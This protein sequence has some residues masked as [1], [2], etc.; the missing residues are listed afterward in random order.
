MGETKE[1]QHVLWRAG[2]GPTPTQ[3][4][5]SPRNSEKVYAQLQQASK[6]VVPLAVPLQSRQGKDGMGSQQETQDRKSLMQ[7]RRQELLHIN[8]AWCYKMATSPEQLRE[9]MTFF[10]HG[11]FACRT[12]RPDFAQN[13]INTLRTHALGKFGDLL[14]AVAQDPAMLQFLNNQQ[15]RKKQPN[16]NFAREVM[17]LFTLGR[18]QYTEQDIK[19]AARA[20]TGWG[21]N[22]AGNYVFRERQ[23]DFEE[24]TFFG[25]TG[26]YTGEDILNMILEKRQTATFLTR[27]LYAFFVNEQVPEAEVATLANAFYESNYDISRL[28]QA[29]FSSESFYAKANIGSKIKSP[30]ELLVGLMRTLHVEFEDDAAL[31]FIQRA[32]GQVLLLPP[33]VSGWP[34]GRSWIDSSSLNYRLKLP[35]WLLYGASS[36]IQLKGDDDLQPNQAHLERGV[37]QKMQAT[38]NLQGLQRLVNG[39]A[40]EAVPQVLAQHLLQVPLRAQNVDLL[41]RMN[42]SLPQDQQLLALTAAILSLPEYQLC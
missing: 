19:N 35:Q 16:E 13:Q 17:E 14:L 11:H 12:Q 7:L 15:N 42:G 2:F 38:V 10:W 39:V 9:K 37:V 18:G 27:K 8:T 32:L 4:Q 31:V 1:V 5:A 23:H 33:N 21:F 20:F 36:A 30:V 29:M 26:Q 40:T 24:K 22:P 41:Q 28:L 3:L 25:K 34:H 6:Q